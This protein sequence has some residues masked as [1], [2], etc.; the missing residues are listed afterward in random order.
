MSPMKRL[1]RLVANLLLAAA[2]ATA[3]AQPPQKVLR[4]AFEVAE[5]SMD[6]AKVNDIYSRTLT[7]HV[8][9][10]PLRYDYLVTQRDSAG[11]NPAD[12]QAT[13]IIAVVDISDEQL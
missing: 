8:F 1:I 12:S 9:E 10:A 2:A 11:E 3:A 5:T 6:P 13:D 7:P 4:Y